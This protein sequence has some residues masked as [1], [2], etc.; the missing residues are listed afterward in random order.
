[1]AQDIKPVQPAPIGTINDLKNN[2]PASDAEK[3][4]QAKRAA[5]LPKW[6]YKIVQPAGAETSLNE[7]GNEGWE[8]VGVTHDQTGVSWAYFKR[9]R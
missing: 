8:L 5:R 2:Q 4:A 3:A 1:M 6:D 7:L 9:P